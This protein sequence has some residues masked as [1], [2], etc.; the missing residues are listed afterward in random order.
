MHLPM[1]IG[2]QQHPVHGSLAAA[3]YPPDNMMVIPPRYLRDFLVADWAPPL[4]L[5]PEVQQ[6]PS[7][8]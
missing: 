5:L 8:R 2:V 1:T 4:L 7:P 6:F 3:V